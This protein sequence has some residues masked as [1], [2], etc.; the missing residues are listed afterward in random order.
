M[1]IVSTDI[2]VVKLF[3]FCWDCD[4]WV[5][6]RCICSS[7]CRG[8]AWPPGDWSFWINTPA[9]ILHQALCKNPGYLSTRCQI[10]I[11]T[12]CG[13]VGSL[14]SRVV[15]RVV[16]LFIYFHAHFYC[17]YLCLQHLHLPVPILFAAT[18]LV[19]VLAPKS[20]H[21]PASAS[22]LPVL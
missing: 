7:V 4:V 5:R 16:Y 2:S 8:W 10:F 17:V 21:H 18:A 6:V 14:L 3:V 9:T 22:A 11:C 13:I 12:A 19:G 20:S 1:L 15:S